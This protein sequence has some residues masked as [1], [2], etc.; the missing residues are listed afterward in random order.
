MNNKLHTIDEIRK[1]QT[2]KATSQWARSLRARVMDDTVE[3]FVPSTQSR[4]TS[5]F[6][7]VMRVFRLPLKFAVSGAFVFTCMLVLFAHE[8]IS[9]KGELLFAKYS[10]SQGSTAYD[11]SQSSL[12]YMQNQM[13]QFAASD[14]STLQS[15]YLHDAIDMSHDELDSLKLM[16]EP[17]KYTQEQCLAVYGVYGN[18]LQLAQTVVENKLR[19]TNN[20]SSRRNLEEMKQVIESAYE[21]MEVRVDAYP[22]S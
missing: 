4:V 14:A 20:Q 18:Y 17:G 7:V 21:E 3:L 5:A 6:D 2:L 11:R 16:G 15:E 10:I 9:A 1:L 12:A 13:D 8:H 22:H 19:D